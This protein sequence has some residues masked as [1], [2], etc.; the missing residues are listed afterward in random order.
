MAARNV[1]QTDNTWSKDPATFNEKP[2]SPIEPPGVK[3]LPQH[4]DHE[5]AP[6]D[7]FELF[8]TD[9]IWNLFVTETNRQADHVKMAKPTNYLAK[10]FKLLGKIPI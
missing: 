7:C 5:T 6:L 1:T 8:W 9:H 10:D 4:F 3:N 2:F